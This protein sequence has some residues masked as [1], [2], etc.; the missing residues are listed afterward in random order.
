MSW[1]LNGPATIDLTVRYPLVSPYVVFYR[2]A[3][4][5]VA[6][7]ETTV[8]EALKENKD[9]III[10]D[11]NNVRAY[12]LSKDIIREHVNSSQSVR[13]ECLPH[14]P[15]HAL[16]VDMRDV[17]NRT[18]LVALSTAGYPGT[19]V[20]EY[21][22]MAHLMSRQQPIFR[23]W[24]VVPSGRVARQLA[25]EEQVFENHPDA[26]GGL[27]CQEGSGAPIKIIVPI[28]AKHFV[29][30]HASVFGTRGEITQAYHTN[31]EM[32]LHQHILHTYAHSRQYKRRPSERKEN[33]SKKNKSTKNKSRKSKRKNVKSKKR[34]SK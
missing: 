16:R 33:K 5:P 21:D 29:V 14:V 22:P 23:I 11:E 25:S 8:L 32:R 4:D 27:H 18:P 20:F 15:L 26:V 3:F 6:Q 13:Y 30:P 24:R 17:Y 9:N 1:K 28:T 31:E 2:S 19:E 10:I 12:V 34:K 7:E